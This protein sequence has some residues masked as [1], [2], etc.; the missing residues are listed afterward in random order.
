[1]ISNTAIFRKESIYI[2]GIPTFERFLYIWAVRDKEILEQSYY[3]VFLTEERAQTFAKKDD[4]HWED[5]LE[6]VKLPIGVLYWE[7]YKEVKE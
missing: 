4:I 6:I 1:M 3:G 2:D 5:F 7:D